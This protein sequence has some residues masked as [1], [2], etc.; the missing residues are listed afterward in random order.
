MPMTLLTRNIDAMKTSISDRDLSKNFQ[1]TIATARGI[2]LPYVSIDWLCIIQD[3]PN[4]IDWEK[5]SVRMGLVYTHSVCVVSAIAS[6]DSRG[7]CFY[8]KRKFKRPSTCVLGRKRVYG[9]NTSLVAQLDNSGD[10]SLSELFDTYVEQA[11]LTTRGWT[12][13]ERVLS[14][15]IVH[16]CDGFV[17]FECNTVRASEY[18]ANGIHY[19]GKPHLL[20]DGTFRSPEDYARLMTADDFLILGSKPAGSVAAN[21]AGGDISDIPR[22]ETSTCSEPRL[23]KPRTKRGLITSAPPR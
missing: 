3:S 11:P 13:Q 10:T 14:R 23:Q 19:A 1:D 8:T 21:G 20:A 18:H 12:F 6:A 15:R 5:E 2:V 4:K 22:D 16:Y 9:K 7:G 17:L